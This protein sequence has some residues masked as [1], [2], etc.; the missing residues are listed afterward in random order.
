MNGFVEENRV[1]PDSLRSLVAYYR[2]PEGS[3]RV[4]EWDRLAADK[5]F[6]RFVGMG[7]SDF[8]GESCAARLSSNG[9]RACSI[10][11][12]EL[13]YRPG[14]AAARE[15]LDI[16]TS[17]S[18]ES[19]EIRKLVE[20]GRSGGHVAVTNDE[21]SSLAKNARLVLPLKAGPE[22]SITTKTYTNTLALFRVLEASLE[23]RSRREAALDALEDAARAMEA[24]DEDAIRAVAGTLAPEGAVPTAFAFSGRC[25]SAVSARQCALT[26]M[27]G[28][29][30]PTSAYAGGA[31]RHGPFEAV[32]PSLGLVVFRPT[33]AVAALADGLARDAA[34]LGSPVAVFDGCAAPSVSGASAIRVPRSRSCDEFGLFPILAA[35]SHNFLLHALSGRFGL[36]TGVFRYGGKVTNKE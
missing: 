12:G 32:G 6:F 20:S 2:S 3:E 9:R 10:D 7:T 5:G 8:A 24:L 26:F 34:A 21:G 4:G 1:L 18:G 14:R 19:V 28:L 25:D 35:R 17:Q 29:K 13:F 33:D 27:E 15:E 22:A 11:A 23:G 16:L 36:E 30:R 31:F